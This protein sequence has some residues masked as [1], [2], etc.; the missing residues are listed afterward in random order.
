MVHLTRDGGRNW[1]PVTPK[2]MPEW[3]RVSMIE[4]SPHDAATAYLAVDRHLLDDFQPYIY[5]TP[6]F[7]KTWKLITGGLP[8]D[9]FV[10]A[11]RED[12]HRRGLLFAGAETGVFVSLDDGAN[13]QPL[14]LNLPPSPVHDLVVKDAD[15]VVATHG[16]AFWILDDLA[17]LRQMNQGTAATAVH[18]FEPT[19]VDRVRD[20]Y[21]TVRTPA[22][23][24]PP[25]GVVV[26]YFLKAPPQG[27]VTLSILDGGGRLVDSFSSTG[28]DGVAGPN[29]Y[30]KTSRV[31]SSAGLNRW[32]WDLRYPG[33]RFIPG[34]V[35]FMHAP[36]APPVGALAPAGRYQVK[37]AVDGT[38]LT[39]PFEIRP[40]PRV[41]A[42]AERLGAQFELHQRLVD[43]LS[44][45][46][47]TVLQNRRIRKQIEALTERAGKAPEVQAA[48]RHI[49]DKLKTI[50][51]A[52][53]EP[54][55]ETGGDAFNFPTRL[56]NKLSILIG[57]VANSDTEPTQ[58][59][60]DLARELQE[61][62]GAE[63]ARLRQIIAVDI[64]ALNQLVQERGIPAIVPGW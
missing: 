24:N 7:G 13:W 57:I 21:S 26:Y 36:P 40:D 18:L 50:E 64:A 19:P 3:S 54:R 9:T 59:S 58:P 49:G 31:G 2:E 30:S 27:E 62:I 29:P 22:G 33:P 12:P 52:L 6:D 17:P 15:L 53:I 56:D 60:Y 14:Q 46:N 34:H 61:R 38:T 8:R 47:D 42:P 25:P 32:V 41:E 55:M 63:L 43:E 51:Q 45:L 35:L 16:R 48:A 11:I 5:K 44:T 4:A 39:A 28:P 20:D 23:E 37:L 1:I 10:R